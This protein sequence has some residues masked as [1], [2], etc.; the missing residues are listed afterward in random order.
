[1]W[2]YFF[3]YRRSNSRIL[4]RAQQRHANSFFRLNPPPDALPSSPLNSRC[5]QQSLVLLIMLFMLLSDVSCV[6]L[7]ELLFWPI[8]LQFQPE[9]NNLGLRG[10]RTS[11]EMQIEV[12]SFCKNI[13][14]LMWWDFEKLCLH[15]TTLLWSF[16]EVCNWCIT[17]F[18]QTDCN[19]CHVLCCAVLNH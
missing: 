6:P 8:F 2:F 4:G 5:S 17:D 16:F 9:T 19:N 18:F 15:P 11:S 7:L 3:N 14:V 10:P 12:Q 1:M 13:K